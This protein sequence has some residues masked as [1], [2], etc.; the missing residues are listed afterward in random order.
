MNQSDTD[1]L[2]KRRLYVQRYVTQTFNDTIETIAPH[3]RELITLI[4]DFIDDA[5]EADLQAL[6]HRRRDGKAAELVRA[7][8]AILR[9]ERDEAE[10]V[11]RDAT[12]Q[13]LKRELIVTQNVV[14]PEKEPPSSAGLI[15]LAVGGMALSERIRAAFNNI[16]RRVI[17]TLSTGADSSPEVIVAMIRGRRSQRFKDGVF[18]WRNERVLRPDIDLIINGGAGHAAKRVYQ[19]NGYEYVQWLATLDGRVC[20]VCFRNEAEGTYPIN[21]HPPY[22]AHPKCRCVL[23]FVDDP[24]RIR[25]ARPYVRDDRP[26]S[27]IP[28]SERPGKIGQTRDT[29][30]QFFDRWTEAEKKDWLGP[31]KYELLRSGKVKSVSELV[32]SRTWRPLRLDQLPEV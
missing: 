24:E 17:T 14:N 7:V 21:R 19:R 13:L 12:E 8:K 11:V 26:V 31:T 32:D 29:I 20:S 10:Q 2:L 4:R 9:A 27:R 18:Y 15:A 30:T 23:Q 5:S 22:P 1:K 6:G 28:K 3:D 25:V 16:S